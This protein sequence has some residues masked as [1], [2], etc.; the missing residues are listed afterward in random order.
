MI[1]AITVNTNSND[2]NKGNSSEHRPHYDADRFVRVVHLALRCL[3]AIENKPTLTQ[4]LARLNI[5]VQCESDRNDLSGCQYD[6]FA[7]EVYPMRSGGL[8]RHADHL[9]GYGQKGVAE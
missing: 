6:L 8:I 1:F 2:S 4:A 5:L 9:I 7:E 3:F